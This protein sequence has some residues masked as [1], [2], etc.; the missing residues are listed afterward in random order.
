MWLTC[1]AGVVK[2]SGVESVILFSLTNINMAKES[3]IW[4][5]ISNFEFI[6]WVGMRKPG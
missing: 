4:F 5:N 2:K 1:H 6:N 3:R